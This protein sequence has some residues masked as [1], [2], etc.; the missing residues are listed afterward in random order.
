MVVLAQ[1]TM[2]DHGWANSQSWS[3]MVNRVVFCK[4]FT[5]VDHGLSLLCP[6]WYAQQNKTDYSP[7]YCSL[8]IA[9]IIHVG[10]N[11]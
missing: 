7:C 3:T 2:P 1:T 4:W 8:K 6:N 9:S 10:P 11:I 5:M